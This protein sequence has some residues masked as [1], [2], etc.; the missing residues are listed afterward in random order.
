MD[1]TPFFEAIRAGDLA[2]VS[3]LLAARP[4]VAGASD[5]NGLSALT[6]AAYGYHWA[7]VDRILAAGPELD[8]FE[9]AIIGDAGRVGTLLD[10]AER[11]RAVE[12]G[13]EAGAEAAVEAAAEAGVEVAA[14]AGDLPDPIDERSAD[15]FTALHLAALFGRTDVVRLLL[16]RG[17]DPRARNEDI[18]TA[19]EL[20][21][22]AGHPELAATIRAAGG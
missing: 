5:G 18:L 1:T 10:A 20:A 8:V 22:R 6:V 19:A 11:E 21:E 16:A 13:V 12:A 4:E 15:G 17:A 9:A 2:G 3:R 14:E 7:I